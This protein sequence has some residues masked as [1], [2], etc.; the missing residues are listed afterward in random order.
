MPT[1]IHLVRHAS[2][3]ALGRVLAGREPGWP[4][5][6]AGK[7]QARMLADLF[8][9]HALRAVI[10]A[11][12]PRC[13]ETAATIAA[14]HRLHV[15]V[16]EG[17]DEI[18]FGDWSGKT[19]AELHEDS[20]WHAWNRHRGLAVPPEGESMMRAQA[21]ALASLG[22]LREAWPNAEVAVVSHA[23]IIKAM[24]LGLLGAP[25]DLMHR[26]VIHPASR[27]IV[28]LHPNDSEVDGVNIPLGG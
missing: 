14:R 27:C 18:D 16:D 5:N 3:G 7:Q 28:R 19:F 6:E 4:L 10:A 8:A 1:T 2:T 17:F 15:Q 25:L 23:D 12:L 21:R 26:M 24:V 13:R 9:Q 22:A 11:P 20:R